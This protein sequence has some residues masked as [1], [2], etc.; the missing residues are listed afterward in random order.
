MAALSAQLL[1]VMRAEKSATSMAASLVAVLAP[2]SASHSA[3]ELDSHSSAL[4]L[5]SGALKAP[6]LGVSWA[7]Q[8]DG[9]TETPS[10]LC[11]VEQMARQ[12]AE[13]WG[14]TSVTL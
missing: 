5:P 14:M 10:G 1:A 13:C 12:L 3:I 7:P 2:M 6:Q 11:S 4:L 9:A 8:S